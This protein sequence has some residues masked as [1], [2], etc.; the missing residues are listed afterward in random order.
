MWKHNM[1]T[2]LFN[3]SAPF[4]TIGAEKKHP[5]PK[6]T[7]TIHEYSSINP[8]RGSIMGNRLS[9]SRCRT[10]SPVKSVAPSPQRTP[11]RRRSHTLGWQGGDVF[12]FIYFFPELYAFRNHTIHALTLTLNIKKNPNIAKCAIH[13]SDGY[14]YILFLVIGRTSATLHNSFTKYH[15]YPSISMNSFQTEQTAPCWVYTRYI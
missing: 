2:Q 8:S 5:H 13:G 11:D 3:F 15:P 12:L 10:K 4:A 9:Q 1:V 7:Y 6:P 14:I